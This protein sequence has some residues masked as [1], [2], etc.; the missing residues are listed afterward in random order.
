MKN[1]L[2]RSAFFIR[3]VCLF[4]S[5]FVLGSCGSFINTVS[6]PA[7]LK[8]IPAGI[9]VNDPLFFVFLAKNFYLRKEYR[10]AINFYEK[11]KEQMIQS[12]LEETRDFQW[13]IYEIGFCFYKLGDYRRAIEIFREVTKGDSNFA[14]RKL[15][16]EMI[17]RIS[18]KRG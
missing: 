18:R 7:R 12:N 14:A 4:L 11:A 9:Q 8:E 13:V 3:I 1:Y 2:F 17:E 15:A 5:F 6:E 16:T 10:R